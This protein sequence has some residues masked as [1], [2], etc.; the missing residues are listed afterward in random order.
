MFGPHKDSNYGGMMSG[1]VRILLAEDNPADVYLIEEALRE[2]GVDFEMLLARDGEQALAMIEDTS[3]ALDVVL[4]DLN[5]PK[6]GGSEVLERL[7]GQSTPVI[8]LTS[9]DSPADK[10]QAIR[11]GATQ[12]IRKPTGLD[13]FLAIGATIKEIVKKT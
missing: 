6:R 13:E 4:L 1:V 8:V 7:Q 9:S 2:H 11:L 12:Y 5:M 10:M 3:C